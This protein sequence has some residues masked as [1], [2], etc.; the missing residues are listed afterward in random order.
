MKIKRVF[1]TLLALC[2]C[3]L[4]FSQSMTDEQVVDYIKQQNAVGVDQKRIAQD[5]VLKGVGQE[6]LMRIR[7][8]Y[9]NVA[10]APTTNSTN[11][12]ER[13]RVNNGELPDNIWD[14]M[15]DA[16]SKSKIFG[17]DIFRS[18]NLSFEPNMNIATPAKYV[19]GPGDE[20]I[21]D[22]YGESQLSSKS[23]I[24]PDGTITVDKIGPISVA[25]LT[26]AQAQSRIHDKVG[27]HYQGSSIR[28]TVGQTRTVLVNVLGEVTTPGTY[29]VSA[30]STVF[31]A[32]YLAGGITDIGTMR[33]IKVSRGGRVISTVDVYDFIVNGTMGGNVMLQDNDVIMVGP[34]ESLVEVTGRI[35]RPMFYEMKKNESLQSLLTLAGGFTGDAYKEKVRVERKSSEGLTVHNVDEWDFTNFHNEDGDVVFI[36]PVI[37]RY[38]NM[39]TVNG[40]VFRPGNYKLGGDVNS[41]KTLISQAGGL[42]EQALLTR[43]VLHRMK[44]DRTLQTM[45]IDLKGIMS[46][47]VPDVALQNEDELIIASTEAVD[48]ARYLAIEGEVFLPGRY[49][50]AEGT[51]IEDLITEAGGLREAASIENVEV[52]R[53]I[54]SAADNAD[55]N[56]MA[57]VFTLNLKE[58]LGIDGDS[59][60]KLMPYDFVT[61]HRNPDYQEQK[62]IIVGGEVKFAGSYIISNKEERLS[63]LIRRAGGLTSKAYANGAQLTRRYTAKEMELKY[64]LLEMA[65]TAADSID[66]RKQIGKTSYGVG[67]DMTKALAAPGSFNDIVLMEGDSIYVP[68]MNTVVKISGDVLYPNTVSFAKGKNASYYINQ[69]GGVSKQGDKSRAYIVYANGQVSKLKK[70]D[71]EPG[72]EIVVP[73]KVK[74]EID[75]N[76]VGMWSTL[77]SSVATVGAVVSTILK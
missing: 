37:E 7:R 75:T 22:I 51:T 12:N 44:E 62:R 33:N 25:G 3:S 67:I 50:F 4:S 9:Q 74:K 60:F 40:A 77:S 65:P 71:I 45:T 61:I 59:G 73:A 19:L 1:F 23:K 38:K 2:I 11:T 21:L 27:A 69:A 55:G 39:A 31:N 54:V 8:R 35:K 42:T 15:T 56:Q 66:A 68:K 16:V 32:L 63:D 17:H 36:A 49:K 13:G 6:Q 70:G 20:V 26:V 52:A 46:G 14:E 64:Q 57:K 48:N 28:L 53:R 30:F 47:N 18:K 76:K 24:S 10:S 58:G 43:A 41:V 34:Y 5:L 29:S 72:C